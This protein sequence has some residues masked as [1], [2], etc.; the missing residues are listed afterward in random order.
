MMV[1]KPFT[2]AMMVVM[3]MVVAV[4][5]MAMIVRCVGVRHV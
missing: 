1:P 2:V 4:M 5:M 3:A